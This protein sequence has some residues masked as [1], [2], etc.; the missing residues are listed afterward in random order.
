MTA[1][2]NSHKLIIVLAAVIS[3]A[4]AIFLKPL[5]TSNH[6]NKQLLEQH[7]QSLAL[8]LA[9]NLSQH[10][11]LNDTI[12]LQA[13]IQRVAQQSSVESIIVY[14][15]NNT[16]LAQFENE[17]ADAKQTPT[18]FT[19]QI[20]I[21]EDIAG[22]LSVYLR[23]N[24]LSTYSPWGLIIAYIA[25]LALL[26]F[27][28]VRKAHTKPLATENSQTQK[29]TATPSIS[30]QQQAANEGLVLFI[31][32]ANWDILF[33]QLNA[34]SR[35]ANLHRL[36][37]IILNICE[38]YRCQLIANTDDGFLIILNGA[39]QE[40][41]L[42]AFYS[43]QLILQ[44][45]KKSPHSM[46]QLN[47]VIQKTVIE[48]PFSRTLE[49]CQKLLS[50]GSSLYELLLHKEIIKEVD[51]GFYADIDDSKDS[52]FNVVTGLS[53]A[54]KELLEK[55]ISQLEN[56]QLGQHKESSLT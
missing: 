14:D 46:L 2:F 27:F 48:T 17:N 12:S 51:L 9:D 37:D 10:I 32:I 25:L 7:G 31:K 47:I 8:H 50:A 56:Q 39:R 53:Q 33:Q 40:E 41:I 6:K 35:A 26:A 4:F 55:Q 23:A 38:L 11:A 20:V 49:G 44:L 16:I 34:E 42:N 3:I 19:A 18:H 22:S 30:E 15:I 5:F 45:N 29:D 36:E 43:A 28:V 52:H 21:G 54:Y 1:L 24:S 13:S